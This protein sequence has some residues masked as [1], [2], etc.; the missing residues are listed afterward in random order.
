MVDNPDPDE[1]G[2]RV[3]LPSGN[4][5]SHKENTVDWNEQGNAEIWRHSW[6]V[7]MN[8]FLEKNN[9]PERVDLRSFESQGIKEK[10]QTTEDKKSIFR[11]TK[12]K[13]C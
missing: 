1:N 5:K 12:R 13:D 9:S 8:S 6:E 10:V 2:E 11:N 4:W 7:K 3:R